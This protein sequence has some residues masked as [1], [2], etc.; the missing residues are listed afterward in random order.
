MSPHRHLARTLIGWLWAGA[1]QAG[2]LVQEHDPIALPPLLPAP[3]QAAPVEPLPLRR[4]D[5]QDPEV[6]QAI[7]TL[8]RLANAAPRT[9]PGDRRSK[10]A[11]ADAAGDAAWT[12]G[13]I[14]LH[15]AGVPQDPALARIWFERAVQRGKREALAG[16]AWC[17]ID[18]CAAWPDPASA[19]QWLTPLRA[20]DLPLAQYL[21]WLA[22]DRLRPLRIATPDHPSGDA[23]PAPADLKLLEASARAGNVHALIE[24]GLNAMAH[25]QTGQALGY[26]QRAAPRSEVATS[27]AAIV[28]EAMAPAASN[29]NP[30]AD[31]ELLQQAQRAHRGDGQPVN[32]AEAIRLYRLAASKGNAE[33]ARMLALIYARPLVNG[34]VDPS[35]MS[36]L[37]SLDLSQTTP[38]LKTP[39]IQ[40]GLS[41]EKTPLIDQLPPQWRQ[42]VS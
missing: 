17:A 27:N 23:D 26:F 7:A 36:Q 24:L 11:A 10:R 22:N 9:R 38:R 32:Y 14:Y 34:N 30:K 15:G 40:R 41:R 31:I 28:R 25:H 5:E 16:M 18:G 35:W 2:V 3:I 29:P 19:R 33:A 4:V 21:Q 1:V 12:L 13:L 6:A 37:G 42:R 39:V 20:V 8:T